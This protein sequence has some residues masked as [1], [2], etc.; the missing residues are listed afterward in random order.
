MSTH[1]APG[2]RILVVE[3]EEDSR[4]SLRLLL[5]TDGHEVSLAANGVDGLA[6]LA[7]FQPDVA[8]VDVG[9]PGMDGYE[10]ARRVRE[11]PSGKKVKL[12]AVTGYGSEKAR[13]RARQAGFDL[14][15]TKPVTYEELVRV[16]R[17]R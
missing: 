6:Q 7:S 10:L 4:E 16:F 8:L 9:L 2:G 5:E 3:D 13:Q 15:V 1:S 11:L 14:H 17:A 12:I